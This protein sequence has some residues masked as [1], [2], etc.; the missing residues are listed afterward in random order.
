MKSTFLPRSNTNSARATIQP[1]FQ[2]PNELM[3]ALGFDEVLDRILKRF[4]QEMK[5]ELDKC[6]WKEKE[7]YEKAAKNYVKQLRP[8]LQRFARMVEDLGLLKDQT[9]LE[10]AL[11][12]AVSAFEVYLRELTVSIIRLNSTTGKISR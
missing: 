8:R 6:K 1:L 2:I 10:Q 9:L 11:I 12:A 4:E 7:N 5:K 3:H